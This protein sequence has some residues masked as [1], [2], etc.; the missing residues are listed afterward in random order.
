VSR[1]AALRYCRLE[2]ITG[3]HLNT[4]FISD[5]VRHEGWQRIQRARRIAKRLNLDGRSLP[6]LR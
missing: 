3:R 5:E 4:A 1:A 2:I 6:E